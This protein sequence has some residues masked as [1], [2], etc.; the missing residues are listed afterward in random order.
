MLLVC[1]RHHRR[2]LV[3]RRCCCC[4]CYSA[5]REWNGS[6]KKPK[7]T[8]HLNIKGSNETKHLNQKEF[9]FPNRRRP[10]WE[11]VKAGVVV[12]AA[13]S[14]SSSQVKA[15]SKR[16]KAMWKK[17]AQIQWHRTIYIKCVSVCVCVS[18][19]C[20]LYFLLKCTGS[21]FINDVIRITRWT[22]F[23]RLEQ[24]QSLLMCLN[25]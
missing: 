9:C 11:D 7:K 12:A 25:T 6:K 8:I 19:V 18:V 22:N 17:S 4:F 20:R 14:S 1:C 24:E 15:K 16:Q 3:G 21:T 23:F 2:C 5:A 10:K 13:A